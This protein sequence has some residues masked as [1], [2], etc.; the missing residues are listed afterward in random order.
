MPM[1]RCMP[2]PVSPRVGPGRVGGLPGKPVA[3]KEPPVACPM[4]S[5]DLYLL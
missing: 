5:K 3:Q 1:A 4:V 2:V